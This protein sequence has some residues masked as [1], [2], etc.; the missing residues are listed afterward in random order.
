MFFY[1]LALI[2]RF[3]K[4]RSRLNA[5]YFLGWILQSIFSDYLLSLQQGL[6]SIKTTERAVTRVDITHSKNIWQLPP[7]LLW[8]LLLTA[9]F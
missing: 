4:I 3:V 9:I 6:R 7:H 1:R 8:A 2:R 5:R